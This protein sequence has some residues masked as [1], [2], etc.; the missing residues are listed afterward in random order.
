MSRRQNSSRE[1]QS[2]QLFCP[3]SVLTSGILSSLLALVVSIAW[4]L[5]LKAQQSLPGFNLSRNSGSFLYNIPTFP[6]GNLELAPV[7]LDGKVVG[8]VASQIGLEPNMLDAAS[9]AQLIHRKLQGV[10]DRMSQYAKNYQISHGISEKLEAV[11]AEQLEINAAKSQ[12]TSVILMAFPKDTSPEVVFSITKADIQRLGLPGGKIAT[13]SVN[14]GREILLQAWKE[15]QPDYLR[16]QARL[17]LKIFLFLIILSLGLFWWQQ[18]LT[19]KSKQLKELLSV[20]TNSSEVSNNHQSETV[21]TSKPIELALDIITVRLE[22]LS[23]RQQS[24]INAFLRVILLGAQILLWVLGLGYLC[25]LF[26]WTRPLS[27]WILGVTEWGG[28]APLDWLIHWGKRATLGVPLMLLVL[29]VG[30]NLVNKGSYVLIDCLLGSWMKQKAT[31]SPASERYQVRGPTLATA[32]KGLVTVLTY[33]VLGILIL[34][35]LGALPNTVTIILGV[36]SLGIS[37]AAQ[38]LIKDVING[39][40]ILLQDW[41]AI[42]D[43]IAI[44]EFEGSVENLSLQMTQLRN[45]EGE[46]ITIPNGTITRVRNKSSG[47]SQVKFSIDVSY[48]ADL[49]EAMSIMKQVAEEIY[50]DPVWHDKLLGSPRMLGVERIEH[51]GVNIRILLKTKPLEQWA[52]AREYR[53]RLKKAFDESDI[54][55]G[56]PRYLIFMNDS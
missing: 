6:E 24:S 51:T 39:S 29:V 22:K 20:T 55:V 50:D 42:G 2:F 45:L 41:Y 5:P 7:F 4:L 17:A 36:I 46:L 34:R 30:V 35:Q 28:L 27:N 25:S 43:W 23:Y 49:E 47:W 3:S 21:M 11:L 48:D 16:H 38:N 12:G 15:R 1:R 19:A 14:Y 10:L 8:F 40:L 37:L 32:V 9:R 31:L 56:L 13:D 18:S 44:D 54:V 33:F 53:R 26:Y 52:V